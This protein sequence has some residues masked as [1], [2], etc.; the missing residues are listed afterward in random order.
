MYVPWESNPQPFA[1]L[2]QCSTTEP[3]RNTYTYYK[4][5]KNKENLKEC[6]SQKCKIVTIPS[7][8]SNFYKLLLINIWD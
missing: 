6:F 8:L 7:P 3:Q 4:Q 1:L 5:D 2:M